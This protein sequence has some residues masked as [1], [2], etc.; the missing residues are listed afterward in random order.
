MG[1][2]F[3]SL[4]LTHTH[5]LTHTQTHTYARTHT[6]FE[7]VSVLSFKS[8]VEKQEIDLTVKMQST[9]YNF[10][11]LWGCA[12]IYLSAGTYNKH[13]RTLDG[14]HFTGSIQKLEFWR[15]KIVKMILLKATI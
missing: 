14:K 7:C 12:K 13:I 4:S 6:H 15:L 8:F 1:V 2:S 10:N 3:L 11:A 5:T 9:S